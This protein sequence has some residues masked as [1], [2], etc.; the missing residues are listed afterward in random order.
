MSNSSRPHGLQNARLP[1][2]SPSPRVCSNSRPSSQWWSLTISSSATPFSF[3]FN[4]SQHQGLF[5]WVGSSCWNWEWNQDRVLAINVKG[6][7]AALY[8][9]GCGFTTCFSTLLAFSAL[10]N[11]ESC[12]WQR[13]S[14]GKG[15]CEQLSPCY[16]CCLCCPRKR[17]SILFMGRP[18]S[19]AVH[20]GVEVLSHSRAR[21]PA[22]SWA[23]AQGK[24]TFLQEGLWRRGSLQDKSRVGHLQC[25][26]LGITGLVSWGRDWVFVNQFT[27]WASGTNSRNSERDNR[28][29]LGG[30]TLVGRPAL[31]F[32]H[33]DFL[34]C[35]PVPNQMHYHIFSLITI[36][37]GNS[38]LLIQLK[39]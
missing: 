14:L 36:S 24:A 31:T 19:A 28:G 37:G 10:N 15:T 16:N 35:F 13:W 2:P 29:I 32:F 27:A 26:S 3:S 30:E 20:H 9:P 4:L 22:A 38:L 11:L 6:D 39:D 12:E 34:L 33:F 25:F 18:A 5:Q 1:C 23:R 7:G 8:F 17:R 21:V